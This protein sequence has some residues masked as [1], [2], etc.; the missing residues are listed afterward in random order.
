MKK[1]LVLLLLCALIC[2][3]VGCS[4]TPAEKAF[5][6]MQNTK[7]TVDQETV[8]QVQQGIEQGKGK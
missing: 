6:Q 5:E 2:A 8:N 4:K 1:A 3:L 7:V